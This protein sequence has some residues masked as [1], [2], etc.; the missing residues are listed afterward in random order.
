MTTCAACNFQEQPDSK[1]CSKCG[2]ALGLE[3]HLPNAL[4]GGTADVARGASRSRFPLTWVVAGG[5][6]AVILIAL[7]ALTSPKPP[8]NLPDRLSCDPGNSPPRV[9]EDG[10][11]KFDFTDTPPPTVGTRK[12]LLLGNKT[13]KEGADRLISLIGGLDYATGRAI[14]SPTKVVRVTPLAEQ[15]SM[16]FKVRVLFPDLPPADLTCMGIR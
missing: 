14:P 2:G 9:W 1:F 12:S 5:G 16:V 10:R 6:A 4:A 13:W 3:P 7:F 15:G 11:M 8:L